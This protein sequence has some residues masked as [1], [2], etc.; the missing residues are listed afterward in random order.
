MKTYILSLNS[1]LSLSAQLNSS[2]HHRLSAPLTNGVR[3][4]ASPISLTNDEFRLLTTPRPQLSRMTIQLEAL[5]K[6][7]PLDNGRFQPGP[8]AAHSSIG[9]LEAFPLEIIHSV[10]DV[11]DLQSLTDFRTVS[12]SARA[13]VDNFPPYDAIVRH[14]P[15]AL[16]AL[17]STHMAAHFTCGNISQALTT[18]ACLDCGQFGPFLDLLTGH[19]RCLTCA[20]Y[21]EHPMSMTASSA[22]KK[23]G[24][25][26]KAMRTLPT[27]LS[28]PGEYSE[29]E[30][31][32]RRRTS[33]VSTLSVIAAAAAQDKDS[34]ASRL[35][36]R[37]ITLPLTRRLYRY[38]WNPHRF[39]TLIRFPAVDLKT[40]NLDWGVCCQACCLG[41]R[42]ENRGY[43]DWNTTYSAVGYLEHFQKCQVSQMARNKASEY[44]V[45]AGG[46]QSNSDY[47]FFEFLDNI[48]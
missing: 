45:P 7:C 6:H 26:L 39:M 21:S 27:L 16:R 10:F 5:Q 46:D 24:L 13:L 43:Y 25:K 18:Q 14:C 41:P 20:I 28:L 23:I 2:S 31:T 47:R 35:G 1:T 9:D 11:L 15:D 17:L 36:R 8:T 48:I 3:I 34:D 37:R 44:I 40:G 19:R 29:R 22:K 32:Y 38:G 42:D 4:M 30:R 33:L 12:W